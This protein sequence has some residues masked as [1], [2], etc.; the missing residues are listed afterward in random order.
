[1]PPKQVVQISWPFNGVI[2][3]MPYA[4]A[5]E[6]ATQDALN[7]RNY[8]QFGR[9]L[10]GGRRTGISKFI[11]SQPSS[12]KVQLIQPVV[13]AVDLVTDAA[14]GNKYAD[15]SDPPDAAVF[16]VEWHPDGDRVLVSADDI[17]GS[18]DIVVYEWSD[19]SGW[20]AIDG[21]VS[22]FPDNNMRSRWSPSGNEIAAAATSGNDLHVWPYVKGSGFGTKST[23][24]LS[25]SS[26][27][28]I[29]GF[30]WHPDGDIVFVIQAISASTDRV[31]SAVDYDTATQTLGSVLFSTVVS[32]TS[33]VKK[34]NL[35]VT[36]T[37]SH[38]FFWSDRPNAVPF[39]KASGFGSVDSA[40]GAGPSG[41]VGSIR[42]D[43]ADSFVLVAIDEDNLDGEVAVYPWDSVSGFGSPIFQGLST[44]H[45]KFAEFSPDGSYVLVGKDKSPWFEVYPWSGTFGTKLADT[46]PLPGN[47]VVAV[48][49]APNGNS[50]CVGSFDANY[51]FAYAFSGAATNP[52]ARDNRIVVVQGGSVYRSNTTLDSLFLVNNGS[53]AVRAVDPISGIEAFQQLFFVDGLYA[54]YNYLDYASNTVKDWPSDVSAG[55]LPRGTDDTSL[56][57][58]FGVLYR[59]RV[60]L[61]GLS[62]EPQNWFMSRAGDPFDWDYAPSTSSATQP[63]AGNNSDAG[64]LGDVITALAPYN[65]DVMM[66][67]GPNSLWI[68]RGDPAAGGQIDNI[69]RQVGVVG[70]RAWT[71]DTSGNLYF[72]AFNGLYRLAGGGTVPEHLSR[73][74]LDKTF[75]NIDFSQNEILLVYDAGWIGVHIF[76]SPRTEPASA[77]THYFWDERQNAFWP[78]Q[79]PTAVGPA[80]VTQILGD[81]PS[82]RAVVMGGYDG[83]LRQFDIAAKDDDGTAINSRVRFPVMQ[84]G[85]ILASGRIDD[86]N[87][88][89]DK[90]SDDVNFDVYTGP[91]PEDADDAVNGLSGPRLR[92]IIS[93][94]RNISIRKRIAQNAL[95]PVIH[96]N[97]AGESWA[98]E[99]AAAFVSV[100]DRMRQKRVT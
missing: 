38:V 39:T 59:G 80:T 25:G 92:R 10:R 41:N 23:T 84:P 87:I 51:V 85:D 65:D 4:G 57:C 18:D 96:H 58:R 34:N 79:Y 13:E 88:V 82:A 62:E 63:V 12:A 14:V 75:S 1:M 52:S 20:G 27:S 56:G 5:M 31:I 16:S 48:A 60:V 29:Q 93:G 94:G 37:G 44:A 28:A 33:G 2:E 61:S 43:P 35:T 50:L 9:R 69:S 8:D 67:G 99:R 83:F 100:L 95:V 91:T 21:Q 40:G 49:W 72:L 22:E 19:A 77:S 70:P 74:K 26:G 32:S 42:L 30:A 54:N 36:S 7:V 64:E 97:T 46:S 45:A 11:D 24:T 47:D 78:D 73:G 53:D 66:M 76:I 17:Q 86:I 68:M 89:L 90:T 6:G 3:N 15:P 81:T 55:S 71:W 98:F